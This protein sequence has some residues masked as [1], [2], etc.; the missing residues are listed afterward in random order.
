MTSLRRDPYLWTQLAGLATLPLWLDACL[1]GL[2]VGEATVPPWLEITTLGLVGTIPCLWMQWQRPFYP[3]SVL[4]IALR[5]DALSDDQRR[6]LSLQRSW[7]NRLLAFFGA[8]GLLLILVLLYQIAPVAASMS[9]FAGQSRA[10]G[11]LIAAIAFLI[12]N[13]FAQ[14]AIASLPLLAASAHSLQTA[15]PYECPRVLTDFTVP[16]IRVWSFL[17][18][19]DSTLVPDCADASAEGTQASDSNSATGTIDSD[20]VD[21]TEAVTHTNQAGSETPAHYPD[22]AHTVSH[23]EAP[24]P[25]SSDSDVVSEVVD[26][27]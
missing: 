23:Q 9:P 2:A 12:A 20:T 25:E 14:V 15:Q 13:F 6:L 21:A 5:P 16:M 4:A 27:N 24:T 1:A 18:E 7:L 3:F 11:W 10:V 19:A 17:P 22:S 26:A 8:A